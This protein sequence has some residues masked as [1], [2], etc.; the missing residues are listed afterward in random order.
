MEMEKATREDILYDLTANNAKEA[1]AFHGL[2]SRK[3]TE[4][5]DAPIDDEIPP[6][7]EAGYV[8]APIGGWSFPIKLVELTCNYP[9]LTD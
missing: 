8:S 9:T 2:V 6:D 5:S 4:L 1:Y 7:E 3:N